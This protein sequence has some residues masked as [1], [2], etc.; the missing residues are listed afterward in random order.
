[1]VANLSAD[2]NV[3]I[4]FGRAF[5]HTAESII[6]MRTRTLSIGHGDKQMKFAPKGGHLR[7]IF[8]SFFLKTEPKDESSK[9]ST[10]GST[11]KGH[12]NKKK[13]LYSGRAKKTPLR[14]RMKQRQEFLVRE[15]K[16]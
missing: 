16:F 13:G 11:K 1:M 10:S 15:A 9:A 4:I 5:L 12:R 8:K 7:R 6:D 3:P 14:I 2:T